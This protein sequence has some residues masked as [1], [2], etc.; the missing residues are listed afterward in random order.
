MDLGLGRPLEQCATYGWWPF[1]IYLACCL[2]GE[3][4]RNARGAS[5]AA[6]S[7]P[8]YRSPDRKCEEAITGWMLAIL[9]SE[10]ERSGIPQG[11]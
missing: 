2:L 11:W 5:R 1:F 6:Q 9:T 10:Q 7:T 8:R 3:S 4:P